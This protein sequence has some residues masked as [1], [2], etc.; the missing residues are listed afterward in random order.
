MIQVIGDSLFEFE[1]NDMPAPESMGLVL[2]AARGLNHRPEYDH[3]RNVDNT[4]V[5]DVFTLTFFHAR[6]SMPELPEV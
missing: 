4:D 2:L 3:C 5:P 1:I 6:S